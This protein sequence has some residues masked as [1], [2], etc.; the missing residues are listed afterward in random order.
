LSDKPVR[1]VLQEAVEQ[2][3][4]R[5]I[6]A[7]QV[8][9]RLLLAGACGWSS[10][11]F[12]A[13][14]NDLLDARQRAVF[15]RF[16]ARRLNSEPVY[17]IL[18]QREFHG[19]LL[20]LSPETLEPRD[21]TECV[22]DLVLDALRARGLT[23]SKLRFADMGTGTGAI[24][25]ALLG[26]LPNALAVA[27]DISE[28]ALDTARKNAVHNNLSERFDTSLGSWTEGLCGRFDFVVSNP[29]YI[30]SKA[31]DDLEAEVR[32]H[33]PRLALDGGVDGLDAYRRILDKTSSYLVAGGFLAL[34]IGFD[35]ADGVRDIA[36]NTGWRCLEVRRDYGK[37]DRAMMFEQ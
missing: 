33:D 18:G 2:F 13:R 5:K 11:D 15:H 32:E 9:A 27:T 37:R 23:G 20:K 8:E 30:A 17:R 24:A 16:V 29:P 4:K 6:E 28:E 34:E 26:E 35:Q 1:L 14:Q 22:V 25:L 7:P 21:D 10:T 19:H 36:L 3:R 12:A 31:I